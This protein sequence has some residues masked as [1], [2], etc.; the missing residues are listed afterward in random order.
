MAALLDAKN[1]VMQFGG[2]KAVDG[3]SLQLG[4]GELVGLIGPNGAG[5]TTVFNVLTGVYKPTSGTVELCDVDTRSLKPFQISHLGMSRT[6]QNI[7]LFRELSVLDNVLIAARQHAKHTM[8]DSVFRLPRHYREEE[9]LRVKA[10]DLLRIFNLESKYDAQSG[11]LPYGEQRKLEI[12]RALATEPKIL[13]LDEPAAGMNHHETEGLMQT[14]AKI[15]RDFKL[16]VL[17]IEHDMKLVMGICERILVLDHG[18]LI[19]QGVPEAIRKDPKV[20]AAYLGAEFDSSSQ[21]G[22]HHA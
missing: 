11:S 9:R 15:R 5:K 14:I 12:I 21:D 4:A 19:S 18:V 17:L 8:F 2:L 13:C 3:F 7:R 10:M 1:V 16:T 22:D 6:F 20:I